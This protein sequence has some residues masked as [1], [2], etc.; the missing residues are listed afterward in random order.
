MWPKGIKK[1]KVCKKKAKYKAWSP[2]GPSN[3]FCKP[4]HHSQY[5]IKM[6]KKGIVW[7]ES[8]LGEI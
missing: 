6:W 5:N 4:K 2:D 3:Y 7:R 8:R 1:C